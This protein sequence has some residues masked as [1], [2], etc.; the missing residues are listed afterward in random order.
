MSLQ[1]Y[2]KAELTRSARLRSPSELVAE[3]EERMSTRGTAGF[4]T[5]SSAAAVRT[6]RKSH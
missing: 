1:E 4:A 5:G 2:L 6:D 3:V